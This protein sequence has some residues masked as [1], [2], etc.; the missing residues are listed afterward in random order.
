MVEFKKCRKCQAN[1]VGIEWIRNSVNDVMTFS[2]PKTGTDSQNVLNHLIAHVKL[3]INK[4]GK[5]PCSLCLFE[6]GQMIND[7]MYAFKKQNNT[8]R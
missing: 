1:R 7:A 3:E 5:P 6:Y 4:D 8:Q 2:K